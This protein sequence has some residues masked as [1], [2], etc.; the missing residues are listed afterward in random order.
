[1]YDRRRQYCGVL[2]T[3][4]T[5]PPSIRSPVPT[6]NARSRLPLDSFTYEPQIPTPKTDR[7]FCRLWDRNHFSL[8]SLSLL[9]LF[10][11][12]NVIVVELGLGE[13]HLRHVVRPK[14]AKINARTQLL[15]D[16]H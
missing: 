10:Q 12:N 6:S 15:R 13:A 5:V 11:K 9:P 4:T 3:P 16:A 8:S 1:M 7:D 2:G 14:L